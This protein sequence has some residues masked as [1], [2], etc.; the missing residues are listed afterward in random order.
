MIDSALK[1]KK[2]S[3]VTFTQLSRTLHYSRIKYNI[4]TSFIFKLYF[5]CLVIKQITCFYIFA[6]N[7]LL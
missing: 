5:L 3:G 1:E 4:S 7:V 2:K 6:D